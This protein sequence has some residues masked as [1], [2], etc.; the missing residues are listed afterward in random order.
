MPYKIVVKEAGGTDQLARV[1]I[2]CPEPAA[3]EILIRQTAVGLNFIDI[4]QRTGLY[5]VPPNFVAGGEAAG[6]IEA[7]GPDVTLK[8]GTRVAYVI[9]G[10]GAYSSH[11]VV[12]E[13]SVVVLPDGISDEIGAAVM[14]KGLTVNYLITHSYPVSRGDTVLVHA[15]AG[16]VGL[17]A[18]QWLKAMGVTAIGTAGGATKCALARAHGYAH[19][20]DYRSED[21][22]ARVME[23]TG[24]EGVPAVYDS[25]GADT[26]MRSLDVLQR[27]GTLVSFGQSSGPSKEFT[28]NDLTRGSL[29]LT[30]PTLFHHTAKPGWMAQAASSL[31]DLIESGAIKITISGRY[32]L[33]EVGQAQD[34]LEARQTT[35]STILIP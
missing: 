19:V 18:G 13:A 6:V 35:G 27:F 29:R 21:F 20:I 25:V 12:P 2:D 15:A 30:R 4:Y 10:G 9:A 1:E 22:V 31:F 33:S 5:P 28:I 8:V 3:G 16:G 26:V 23:I 24:G 14:L 34:A 32:A 17:I 7:V 11:R